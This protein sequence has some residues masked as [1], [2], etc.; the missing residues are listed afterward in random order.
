MN[1]STVEY[2]MKGIMNGRGKYKKR[3]PLDLSYHQTIYFT[4]TDN[5]EFSNERKRNGKS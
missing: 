3:K 2:T 4:L 1:N 5:L